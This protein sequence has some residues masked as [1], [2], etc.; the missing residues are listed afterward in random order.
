MSRRTVAIVDVLR[1]PGDRWAYR[2]QCPTCGERLK[3]ADEFWLYRRMK[4]RSLA[5]KRTDTLQAMRAALRGEEA[6]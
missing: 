6:R 1:E 4:S 2:L 5:G 3:N